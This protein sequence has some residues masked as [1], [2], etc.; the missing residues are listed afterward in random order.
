LLP[1]QKRNGF[2]IFVT[3]LSLTADGP[4]EN[5]YQM[6]VLCTCPLGNAI[7]T[8]AIENCPENVG[9]IQKILFQRR[10]SSGT[11]LNEFTIATGDPAE[12]ANWTDLLTATDGTKVTV[13]P[14]LSQPETEPGAPVTYG[15][16]N[17][18]IGG[19]EV[20]VGRDPTTF[21]GMFLN[22][23]QKSI[24][25]MKALECE[26]NGNEATLAV[27]FVDEFGQIIGISD[28]IDNP[29][30]VRPI[31]I[32]SLFV[33]DKNFGGFEE[34]DTNMIQFSLLPNW[35]DDLYIVSPDDFD[36]LTDLANS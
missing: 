27:Y 31:P 26:A 3:I 4:G 6:S 22:T 35:S 8:I 12:V 1:L 29:T 5:V 21:T 10:Y 23:S 18:T 17:A 32:R 16:G 9:Q 11:T 33:G 15:G 19:I 25:D 14:Y 24:K 36:P 20:I 34:P 2:F 7:A 13:S 30:K 28:D